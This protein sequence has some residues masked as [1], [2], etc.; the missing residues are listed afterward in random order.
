MHSL[1][2]A[3]GQGAGS[4]PRNGHKAEGCKNAYA[5]RYAGSAREARRG[6]TWTGTG[7]AGSSELRHFRYSPV[8]IRILRC[9]PERRTLVS[10]P[11]DLDSCVIRTALSGTRLEPRSGKEGTGS[12]PTVCG[13]D[14]GVG[15]GRCGASAGA[16]CYVAY[17][18]AADSSLSHGHVVEL[19]GPFSLTTHQWVSDR[20]VGCGLC[21]GHAVGGGWA[22]GMTGRCSW[23]GI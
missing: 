17:P 10:W 5:H 2:L 19:N 4:A 14:A 15:Q 7:R 13:A 1:V 8:D 3:K 11:I 20:V 6:K 18:S 12:T 22:R 23:R 21:K 9:A 16:G